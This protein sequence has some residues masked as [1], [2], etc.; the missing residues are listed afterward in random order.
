MLLGLAELAGSLSGGVGGGGRSGGGGSG[1]SGTGGSS[2]F[3]GCLPQFGVS[4]FG[5]G[6]LFRSLA[7]GPLRI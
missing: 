6:K 3:C 5:E 7:G 1:C 4:P 2:S